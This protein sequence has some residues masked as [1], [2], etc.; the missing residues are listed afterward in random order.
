MTSVLTLILISTFAN[1]SSASAIVGNI[2]V[3]VIGTAAGF[4]PGIEYQVIA[5]TSF[6]TLE[7]EERFRTVILF[8]Y[9][10]PSNANFGSQCTGQGTLLNS[11]TVL[12][13]FT[14]LIPNVSIRFT[15]PADSENRIVCAF[16]VIA[17]SKGLYTGPAS[18]AVVQAKPTSATP[19]PTATVEEPSISKPAFATSPKVGVKAK[20]T[21]K[22]VTL[23]G[24]EFKSRSV[25]LYVC[26]KSD[27][28]DKSESNATKYSDLKDTDAKTITM[29]E[30][31]GKKDQYVVLYD[32]VVYGADQVSEKASSI[33][34]LSVAT[35]SASPTVTEEV[36]EATPEAT[37]E[38]MA[39]PTPVEAAA[40]S[41]GLLMGVILGVLG[42]LVITLLIV[43]TVLLSRKKK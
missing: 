33:K 2:P 35:A 4:Y 18:Y 21:I 23:N 26:D 6:V 8:A 42:L 40:T 34:K 37:M 38:E 31:K 17:T 22:E 9:L 43:I 20:A 3:P 36:A 19:T 16:A 30:A 32:R 28:S 27:C 25:T 1:V 29:P 41:S 5:T 13:P 10:L 15:N 11:K 39:Q 12:N 24:N 7:Q 14:N